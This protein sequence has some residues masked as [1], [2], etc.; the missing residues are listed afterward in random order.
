[1]SGPQES[2]KR[3]LDAEKKVQLF[4][5]TFS[6]NCVCFCKAKEI[7]DAA[8]AKKDADRAA[9]ASEIENLMALE[10]KKLQAKFDQDLRASAN[11]VLSFY[12]VFYLFSFF[13]GSLF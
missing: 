6:C 2:M 12:S 7:V 5:E 3:L 11:T 13:A 10:E 9:M 1:M 4:C 8:V